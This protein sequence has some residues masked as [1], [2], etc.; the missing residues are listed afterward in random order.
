MNLRKAPQERSTAKRIKDRELGHP[1][2]VLDTRG[3]RMIIYEQAEE[4]SVPILRSAEEVRDVRDYLDA[5]LEYH[6]EQEAGD[7]E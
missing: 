1:D 4:K 5:W 7:N 2:I 3:D 6:D